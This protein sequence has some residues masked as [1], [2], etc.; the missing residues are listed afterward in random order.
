MSTSYQPGVS[1]NESKNRNH[2]KY[3]INIL[4]GFK[5]CC[6]IEVHFSAKKKQSNGT[7][8]LEQKKVRSRK[9][10]ARKR[11][12]NSGANFTFCWQSRYRGYPW[13]RYLPSS[14]VFW[15]LAVRYPCRC[16][17]LKHVYSVRC[18]GLLF[19]FLLLFCMWYLGQKSLFSVL[20]IYC[21]MVYPFWHWYRMKLIVL[22]NRWLLVDLGS[23]T[24]RRSEPIQMKLFCCEMCD[25]KFLCKFCGLWANWSPSIELGQS[26][27]RKIGPR[28]HWFCSLLWRCLWF[29]WHALPY[30]RATT[31]M[32]VLYYIPAC[33]I[34]VC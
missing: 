10:P 9:S 14:P 21:I 22:G 17:R 2:V 20:G 11:G 25:L 3:C 29:L 23:W 16:H 4:A 5:F 15:L 13:V 12:W 28:H 34:C 18:F 27:P 26:Q 6:Y 30:C 33:L 1:C 24:D 8:V 31:Y 7:M 19:C 32:I